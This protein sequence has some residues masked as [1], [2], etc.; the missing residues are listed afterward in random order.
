MDMKVGSGAFMPTLDAARELAESMMNVA[1]EVGLKMKLIFTNMDEPLGNAIGNWLE[2]EETMEAL[3]GNCP[4]D[5]REI[6]E[7]IA[8]AM[9]MLGGEKSEETA[10]KKVREVWE[11]GEAFKRFLKMVELQGGD[12]KKSRERFKNTPKFSLKSESDGIITA[13]NTRE[14]GLSSIAL[15]A[16]RLKQTDDIDYGAGILLKKKIGDKVLK[17]EE[18]A[19]MYASDE[20]RFKSAAEMFLKALKIED[21][22]YFSKEKSLILDEWS[23]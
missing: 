3:K 11:S 4:A 22:A 23:V 5:I 21:V 9:L 8:A 14:I 15:G 7:K 18:I 13:M 19:V 2:I 20:S 10:F 16:G 1:R 6:T 12:L 17:G